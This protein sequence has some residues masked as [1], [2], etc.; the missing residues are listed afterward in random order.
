MIIDLNEEFE[1][2]GSEEISDKQVSN[3]KVESVDEKEEEVQKKDCDGS[4]K[5]CMDHDTIRLEIEKSLEVGSV[6]ESLDQAYVL[7][8]E[9]GRIIGFSVKKGQQNDFRRSS[10]VKM[11]VYL[12]PCEDVP[13]QKASEL[14]VACF[15]KQMWRTK[16]SAKTTR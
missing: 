13:G 4:E 1:G 5:V 2:E 11:K 3:V 7:Y 12:C 8:Y 14:K 16:C 15:K 6:V 10:E 9:Y